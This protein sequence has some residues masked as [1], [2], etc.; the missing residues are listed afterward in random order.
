MDELADRQPVRTSE[1]SRYRGVA[2][3]ICFCGPDGNTLPRSCRLAKGV[4][5]G[6]AGAAALASIR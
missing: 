4:P 6:R 1:S 3:A 2:G 5:G